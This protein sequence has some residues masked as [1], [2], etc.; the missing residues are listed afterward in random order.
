MVNYQDY[1]DYL[2]QGFAS[3]CKRPGGHDSSQHAFELFGGR[4]LMALL[5]EYV[6]EEPY[7]ALAM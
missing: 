2:Y 3:R 7:I 6:G 1:S 5:R 4:G